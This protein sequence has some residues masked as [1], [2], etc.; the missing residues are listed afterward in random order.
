MKTKALSIQQ[1]W[2][3]AILHAGKDIENRTWKTSHRGTILIHTGKRY[4]KIGH[5]YIED[6][7]GI[8][9]PDNLPVGG[10]IG[11]IDI[12][13]CVTYNKSKWF[14]G[15]YGFVL[16]NAEPLPFKPY[17]GNLGLFDVPWGEGDGG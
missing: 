9:I 7:L 4:D 12:L 2:T 11:K 15:P 5:N 17:K 14:S 6:V 16:V 10:V 3:W 8:Q 1:P 13:D